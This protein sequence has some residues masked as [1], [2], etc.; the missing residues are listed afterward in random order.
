MNLII[1]TVGQEAGPQYA[2]DVN[3]SLTLLDQHDHSPGKGVQITPAGMDINASL[4]FN[5]NPLLSLSYLSFQAGAS[6]STAV[7][8][9]SSAPV[10]GINELFYT[11]S[12]G[13][14]TQITANGIVNATAAA[15]PGESYDAGTFIWVQTQSSLPTRPANFDIGSV[16]IRPNVDG[17]TNGVVLGPPNAIS[18]Q[19]NI[20]LP[21]VPG[22]T[23]IMQ[24]DTSG[25]MLASLVP[26]N[27][28]IV[29]ASQ[30]LKVGN[31]GIT[32]AQIAD[33]TITN[34][35]L[36]D[37][38]I[39]S[40]GHPG[41]GVV[42]TTSGTLTQILAAPLNPW[43]TSINNSLSDGTRPIVI[44][45][46][47][48]PNGLNAFVQ[49]LNGG[50]SSAVGV[51]QVRMLNSSASV[52]ATWEYQYEISASGTSSVAQQT[53]LNLTNVF[54]PNGTID[55]YTVQVYMAIT[56]GSSISVNNAEIIA[57]EL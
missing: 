2:L 8:S 43:A 45:I 35:Q 4:S 15:I 23:G 54:F 31:K 22:A 12:N 9:V 34:N 50:S 29:I 36:A 1:P 3:N 13:T 38:V 27:S 19:Y 30:V 7:Q 55:T 25:N 47:A 21:Q 57:Y 16:T 52:V 46:Q 32:N 24:L 11:D 10:S 5:N 42:S 56:T 41:V 26:D 33:Q 17:T 14:Q 40:G 20:Q 28:T 37:V 48:V 18:S 53:P 49:I 6:A 51:L 44:H 39:S